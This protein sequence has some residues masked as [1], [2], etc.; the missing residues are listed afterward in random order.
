MPRWTTDPPATLTG[1]GF[2][3]VRTPAASSLTACITSLDMIG[4]PT[5]YYQRRTIPCD[6]DLCP[7]CSE[8]IGW[9]W[10]GWLACILNQTQEHV[11]FE[12]TAT[13]AD[14][15]KPYRE[16]HGT[17]RG[18]VFTASRNNTRANARVLIRCR[19]GDL[20]KIQLPPPP[21]I[22]QALAH[23]WGIPVDQLGKHGRMK[24]TDRL[25]KNGKQ[26]VQPMTPD[27]H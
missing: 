7:A 13:A 24:Y 21:D 10:H 26:P 1:P 22:K 23:I 2:R 4:C 8:G 5:H 3:L 16:Q 25:R 19:P 12:F 6:D 17:L 18:C 14:F 20:T 11:L 9:R 27:A 15:F